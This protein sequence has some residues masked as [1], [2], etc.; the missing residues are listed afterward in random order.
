[1][2][3]LGIDPGVA[4]T[5]WGVIK[6]TGRGAT[7]TAYGCVKTSSQIIFSGRLEKIYHETNKIIKKYKPERIAVEEIFFCKNVKTALKV[8]QARGVILLS[9]IQSKIPIY[10]FTPLEIKQAITTY[11]RAEKIQ[12]QRM[13]QRLLKLKKLPQPDDA[14]DALAVALCCA[15]TKKFC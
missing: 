4:T 9:A 2:I 5:G 13:V 7:A 8:G 11:G 10:E 12:V 15:Q 14:A 3:V 1:M 6:F